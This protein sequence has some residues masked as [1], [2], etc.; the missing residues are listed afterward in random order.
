M[1][2]PYSGPNAQPYRTSGSQYQTCVTQ[3]G[4]AS[5]TDVNTDFVAELGELDKS[6]QADSGYVTTHTTISFADDLH[7]SE[8]SMFPY[9]EASTY[10]Y[11]IGH[12]LEDESRTGSTWKVW[13][14]PNILLQH[15]FTLSSASIKKKPHIEEAMNRFQTSFYGFR[16]PEYHTVHK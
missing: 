12:W 8:D 16:A 5:V 3:G 2:N 1:I 14:D 6:S 11:G 9:P 15:S 10:L 13:Q 4:D 7:D